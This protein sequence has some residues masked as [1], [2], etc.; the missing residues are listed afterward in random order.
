MCDTVVVVRPGRVLFAKNSD[1]DP[2]EAQLLYWQPRQTHPA[3][4]ELRCTWVSVPQVAETHAV[5][6]SRPFWCWGAEM[7]TNEHGVTIGNEAVF[8]RRQM[9]P[10]GL[11]GLDLLRLALERA[12]TAA[13]AVEVICELIETVGQGGGAGLE[14]QRFRYHNSFLVADPSGA[15]VLET[16]DRH[17]AVEEVTGARAISNALTISAFAERHGAG[18]KSWVARARERRSRSQ[19]LAAMVHAPGDL[20]RLLRDHGPGRREPTYTL[21]NGCMDTLCMHAGGVAAASQTT[22]SWVAELRPDGVQHWVTGT[23]APCTGLFKPVD[24]RAP[25]DLGPAPTQTVDP[26]SVWWRHEELHRRVARNPLILLPPIAR[27]RD[28]VEA[29]WLADPPPPAAAWAEGDRLLEGWL[30]GMTSSPVADKRPWFVRRYWR[31]RNRRAGLDL[32]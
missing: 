17:W 19:T 1:R 26:A 6:L 25:L 5:L 20:M 16:A 21:W 13:G 29:R 12:S 15:F 28:E 3:G 4:A 7:G 24:V 30:A 22:G 8:T 32:R 2:N 9:R 10:F 11:T 27:E 23:A 31:R 14:N 18:F